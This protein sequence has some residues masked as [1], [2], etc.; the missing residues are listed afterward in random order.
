MAKR[1]PSWTQEQYKIALL[2]DR[3]PGGILPGLRSLAPGFAAGEGYSLRDFDTWS[4]AKK[5]RVRDYYQEVREFEAQ[6]VRIVRPRN[7]ANLKKLQTAFHADSKGKRFKVA[8]V[9]DPVAPSLPGA[10]PAP[11][12][13]TYSKDSVS[14]DAGN[15]RRVYAAFDKLALVKNAKAEV[16][17]AAS[18]GDMKKAKMYFIKA[19]KY[20][21]KVEAYPERLAAEVVKLM[22]QYD[23]KKQ[24]PDSSGNRGDAPKKHHWKIWLEGI[25]GYIP[26]RSMNKQKLRREID[27]GMKAAKA[28]Q[29]AR[30]S[31]MR[32]AS[33]KKK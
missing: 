20:Q 4:A 14:V 3:S 7:A 10:K 5:R 26:S 18:T 2:G 6:P 33:K 17:R 30:K 25:I 11:L 12:K 16:L 9:P 24:L 8:F 32:K 27:K 21:M 31:N 15:Y 23:G 29:V 28:R 1:K 19:G 22:M 13:I